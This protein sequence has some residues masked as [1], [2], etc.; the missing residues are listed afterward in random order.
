[1]PWSQF[2][3]WAWRGKS[4]ELPMTCMRGKS[5]S[6]AALP[7]SADAMNHL[8]SVLGGRMWL[9]H[10]IAHVLRLPINSGKRRMALVT[11]TTSERLSCGVS[12]RVPSLFLEDAAALANL[13][14]HVEG[15]GGGSNPA[16]VQLY[17]V[18]DYVLEGPPGSNAARKEHLGIPRPASLLGRKRGVWVQQRRDETAQLSSKSGELHPRD[19]APRTSSLHST[20]HDSV[21]HRQR[22]RP[23]LPPHA[24][25]PMALA[26]ACSPD[27][28]LALPLAPDSPNSQSLAARAL[29]ASSKIWALG[30][31]RRGYAEVAPAGS[32]N[33][34][35]WL[36]PTM[37]VWEATS[38]VQIALALRDQASLRTCGR[39]FPPLWAS[40]ARRINAALDVPSTLHRHRVDVPPAL[41]LAL[42][43][44]RRVLASERLWI[45]CRLDPMDPMRALDA[46]PRIAAALIPAH[47]LRFIFPI[48][49]LDKAPLA[50]TRATDDVCMKSERPV[51]GVS[52]STPSELFVIA[53]GSSLARE[54]GLGMMMEIGSTDAQASGWGRRLGGPAPRRGRM[55]LLSLKFFSGIVL[56]WGVVGKK[57]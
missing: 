52:F 54:D 17:G 57:M 29:E 25:S 39:R 13:E 36:S 50:A 26:P 11:S 2:L 53:P 24:R 27:H 14:S 37:D 4:R 40:L 1:M 5:A 15:T 55:R 7:L 6:C 31:S 9:Y 20:P 8:E 23:R 28:E 22:H 45:A 19:G 33:I 18:Q 49:Y 46:R 32:R 48:L 3:A 35:A 34:A 10:A 30:S 51:T 42:R 43:L 12:L 16:G 38:G 21:S 44:Q 47:L 41:G 56:A